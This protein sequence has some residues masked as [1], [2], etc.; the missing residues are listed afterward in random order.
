MP[1]TISFIKTKQSARARFEKE[2][3]RRFLKGKKDNARHFNNG[4][5][6]GRKNFNKVILFLILNNF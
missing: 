4:S 1:A 5:T 6:V 3:V 2:N